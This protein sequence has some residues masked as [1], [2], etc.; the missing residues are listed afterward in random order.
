MQPYR[1]ST[2]NFF[3]DLLRMRTISFYIRY[4]NISNEY[5]LINPS[6]ILLIVMLITNIFLTHP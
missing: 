6:H 1:V 5:F 2:I 4:P 3:D